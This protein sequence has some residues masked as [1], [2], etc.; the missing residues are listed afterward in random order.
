MTPDNGNYMIA[1]YVL[2]AVVYGGYVV[3]LELR[4]RRLRERLSRLS[5]PARPTSNR[6]SGA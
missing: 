2:A 5:A 6:A 4:A 1:A 3:S